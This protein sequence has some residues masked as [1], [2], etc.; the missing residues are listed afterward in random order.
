MI[1]KL[2]LK[3]GNLKEKFEIRRK[4][5][6]NLVIWKK[7]KFREDFEIWKCERKIGNYWKKLE[8]MGEKMEI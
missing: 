7:I 5:G 8:I 6:N 3:V 2:K 4:I 1:C